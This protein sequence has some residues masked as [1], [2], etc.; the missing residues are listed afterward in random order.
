MINL[1]QDIIP[2]SAQPVD[3]DSDHDWKAVEDQLGT[4]LP[5]DYK[6]FIDIYG[7]GIIG[8]LIWIFNPFTNNDYLNLLTQMGIYRRQYHDLGRHLGKEAN[9]YPFFPEKSGLLPLGVTENG[10][11]LYWLTRGEPASWPVLVNGSR[12][13]EMEIHDTNLLGF[14]T[15]LIN[16]KTKSAFIPFDLIDNKSLFTPVTEYQP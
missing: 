2:L 15:G 14:L 8:R 3:S 4:R 13:I 6:Q 1:F 9:P 11:V 10:D 12:R 7:T 16:R 5:P